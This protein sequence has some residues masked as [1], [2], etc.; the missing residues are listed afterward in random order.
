MKVPSPKIAVS[1]RARLMSAA[2]K[3]MAA[4]DGNASWSPDMVV[5]VKQ[6]YQLL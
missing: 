4:D 5:D 1:V 2:R 6:T 3:N